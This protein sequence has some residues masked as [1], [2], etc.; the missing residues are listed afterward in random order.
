MGGNKKGQR[1]KGNARPSSSGRSAQLLSAS[2]A[3]GLSGFVG[4]GALSGDCPAYIPPTGQHVVDDV[5]ATV[6]SDFRIVMRKL[7]KRDQT[8]RLKALQELLDLVKEK[9]T[10]LVKGALPFW[11]RLYNKLALDNDRRV[12]E[13]THRVHEQICLRVKKGLAPFTKTLVGAWVTSLNDPFAP[14]A[15]AARA[16]FEAA[17]P[18]EKQGQVFSF[19]SQELFSYM[20]DVILQQSPESV[21]DSKDLSKDEQESKYYRWLSSSLL[22]LKT[23]LE[24]LSPESCPDQLF[25][26]LEEGKFWKAAKHKDI[27][28]RKSWYSLTATVSRIPQASG[29]FAP[30]LCSL[31]LGSLA[32]TEPLVAVPIWEATLSVVSAIPDCWKHVDA[33]KAVLP[34]L[35]RVLKN[36]GFGSAVH[37]HPNLLPFLSLIPQDVMGDTVEFYRVFFDA[38]R[39]GLLNP[40]VQ[41]S[42]SEC[43]AVIQSFTECLRYVVTQHLGSDERSVAIRKLLLQE[44]L[45]PVM[46]SCLMDSSSRLWPTRLYYEFSSLHTYL[47]QKALA[48]DTDQTLK[49]GYEECLQLLWKKLLE[50]GLEVATSSPPDSASLRRLTTLLRDIHRPPTTPRSQRRVAIFSAD[51]EPGLPSRRSKQTVPSFDNS[52][53]PLEAFPDLMQNTTKICS[54][55]LKRAR[56]APSGSGVDLVYVEAVTGLLRAV[57]SSGFLKALLGELELG[58][59]GKVD[60][61]SV[62]SMFLE[63]LRP[64]VGEVPATVDVEGYCSEVVDCLLMVSFCA[65]VDETVEFFNSGSLLVIPVL[66]LLSQCSQD[67]EQMMAILLEKSLD[68]WKSH[69]GVREWLK[70]T[71]LAEKLLEL[72]R[73][74][75]PSCASQSE[76]IWRKTVVLS[77]C[78]ETGFFSEPLIST[79]NLSAILSMLR[80]TLQE[81]TKVEGEELVK[82][83]DFVCE[84]T[85]TLFSSYEGCWKLPESEEFLYTLFLLDCQNSLCS[86][87]GKDIFDFFQS[88]QRGISMIVKAR[89]GF[90]AP[91]G[92]LHK[93]SSQLNSLALAK[94]SHGKRIFASIPK[95]DQGPVAPAADPTISLVLESI[96][97]TLEQWEELAQDSTLLFYEC[98]SAKETFE[99]HDA[100][101]GCLCGTSQELLPAHLRNPK[102]HPVF[103][104]KD[105]LARHS[106]AAVEERAHITDVAHFTEAIFNHLLASSCV[107]KEINP[108]T[109]SPIVL[110]FSP[111]LLLARCFPRQRL[112]ACAEHLENI[113]AKRS[114]LDAAIEEH[115]AEIFN[116][117][118]DRCLQIVRSM[119]Q[120]LPEDHRWDVFSTCVACLLSWDSGAYSGRGRCHRMTT[121]YLPAETIERWFSL[122]FLF[123]VVADWLGL[124]SKTLS[125]L[126]AAHMAEAH[127]Q[128]VSVLRMSCRFFFVVLK[129]C[130]EALSSCNWDFVL[131]SL[132]MWTEK[133]S[134]RKAVEMFPTRDLIFACEL[135]S[136][137]L[138][139]THV[140]D[141]TSSVRNS[142]KLPENFDTEWS[143]FYTRAVFSV[144]VPGFVDI[145]REKLSS[146]SNEAASLLFEKLSSALE[147]V[148]EKQAI[149]FTKCFQE[150]SSE[151]QSSLVGVLS[152]LTPLITSH[153]F[154]IFEMYLFGG[155]LR[156]LLFILDMCKQ[157]HL[158]SVSR[159]HRNKEKGRPTN[160]AGQRRRKGC[161]FFVST[162]Q[163]GFLCRP[164]STLQDCNAGGQTLD[165]SVCLSAS[166]RAFPELRFP[167]LYASYLHG[168]GMLSSLLKHLFCLMPSNISVPT[169]SPSRGR[170]MFTEPATLNP[171]A[172]EFSSAKLQHVAC[173]VYLDTICKLPALVRSW[174]SSQNKRIMDHVEKFTS[175]HVTGVIS[176]MEIQAVQSADV[177]FENMTV[178]GRPSAREVVATYTIEEVAI[179]LVVKLPANHPLGVVVIDS[180]RRVGVNQSQWRHWLLQLT[181]FLTHQNGSIL[182]GLALWKRNVDKRFEGVEECMICFYVLHGATCQLPKLTCRTCKKRFHSAC[183]FKWFSTSNNST[184]PLCRNVF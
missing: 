159:I 107:N 64:L 85:Q 43:N 5:D 2:G 88:W 184:C 18:L 86:T 182:D 113:T 90:M 172:E 167:Y 30:K 84:V 97:P 124:L 150:S 56:A 181:T 13:A 8:T 105:Y 183:L 120:L 164:F 32:E 79:S 94:L 139:V 3:A 17:F 28:V 166:R 37:I 138:E 145:A 108:T 153:Y 27:M 65:D 81:F 147:F 106:S 104:T 33:R 41:G 111:F 178:K 62:A 48:D 132:A 25:S 100:V 42:V 46:K 9:D 87:P 72:S 165:W 51:D 23:L 161:L 171:Q 112:H 83:V 78:P 115:P 146:S 19:F 177:T 180:G 52:S 31:T 128:V 49:A 93:I 101:I 127:P 175:R 140:T 158:L 163:I 71:G 99:I 98:T 169:A 76:L 103:A 82:A 6:D 179:E 123:T 89:G 50:V 80:Q 74:L 36:G 141:R 55:V 131:L 176:S 151:N 22:G 168:S 29:K 102:E 70:S 61:S 96:L 57:C 133:F 135:L 54:E 75:V 137:F 67:N 134:W 34:Q 63:F 149:E 15:S 58:H 162:A 126:G 152:K 148:S 7:T 66:E 173:R 14:S 95:E 125:S 73:K 1:T 68:C 129:C 35:W 20:S 12:R 4:F 38:F 154:S 121:R 26:I 47:L 53:S 11:P 160:L 119:L 144:L 21:P 136:L 45:M 143:E 16:A 117:L 174:W 77:Q 110:K 142:C 60:N 24:A 118:V 156:K 122:F 40:K 91:E 109:S 39:E 44:Q 170:T 92:V 59:S 155:I 10:E 130:P 157:G 69:P 116:A 114:A